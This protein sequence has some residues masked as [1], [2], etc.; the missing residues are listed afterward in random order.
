[1]RDAQGEE[2]KHFCMDLEFL[3]RRTPLWREIAAGD[4]VPGGRHRRARR[5]GRGGGRRRATRRARRAARR[6][7]SLGIGSLQGG[8]AMNH[9]LREHAPITDA[10]WAADRRGGARAAR[11]GAR[12]AQARRLRRARTAGSTRRPTSAGPSRSARRPAT[13]VD[14][15]PA[16]RAAARRAARAVR[17]SRAPSSRDADRGAEDVDLDALDERRPPHRRRR[18]RAP[19]STAGRRPASPASPRRRRTSRSRSASDFERYP[20]HVAKAVETLL[21]AG[22]AGPYGLA[23][24]PDAY[25]RVVETTEH[26]GYPLLDHLRKI[27][28]GPIVWAPGVRGRGRRSACAAATSCSSPARTSRSATTAT[29]PTPSSSTSRRAS[30]SASPRPRRPSRSLRKRRPIGA[31]LPAPDR[32]ESVAYARYDLPQDVLAARARSGG[33]S[34]GDAVVRV[35]PMADGPRARGRRDRGGRG[36]RDHDRRCWRR[37]IA[38]QA[39]TAVG[40]GRGGARSRPTELGGIARIN[41]S[42]RAD[43]AL[44]ARAAEG[45]GRQMTLARSPT[46]VL[47]DRAGHR[48][49]RGAGRRDP[50]GRARRAPSA[51]IERSVDGLLEVAGKVAANTANIP[52]LEA[53]APGARR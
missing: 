22:I 44:G 27:L 30:A 7:E 16:P 6:R 12:R 45:G 32:T 29:T 18:E 37:R 34:H 19:S 14:G 11:A 8:R 39:K 21:A 43:P 52:Q 17:A 23:L 15:A 42:G 25:T 48:P 20:R 2:F 35:R 28:G 53:T 13:G 50:A 38:K 41:D 26:G 49:R 4:P 9:L 1:M 51:S 40:G 5:G 24:G 3:L 47:G 46:R 31:G 33:E 36:D 10:G